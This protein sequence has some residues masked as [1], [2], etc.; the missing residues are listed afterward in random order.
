MPSTTAYCMAVEAVIASAGMT[1]VAVIAWVAPAIIVRIAPTVT[2]VGITPTVVAIVI[3][4]I[5]SVAPAPSVAVAIVPG[6]IPRVVP[7][8][9]PRIIAIEAIETAHAAAIGEVVVTIIAAATLIHGVGFARVVCAIACMEHYDVIAKRVLAY[10]LIVAAEL[11]ATVVLVDVTIATRVVSRLLGIQILH[12]TLY[13]TLLAGSE[14]H[15]VLSHH[16]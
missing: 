5:P 10:L 15:I 8:I 6:V 4:A 3:R 13:L 1:V 14:V 9:I 7:W 2:I 11:A 12:L 16:R